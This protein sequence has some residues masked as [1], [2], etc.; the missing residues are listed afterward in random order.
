MCFCQVVE[1]ESKLLANFG[2]GTS[3]AKEGMAGNMANEGK[4]MEKDGGDCSN[5]KKRGYFSFSI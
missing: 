5:S 4:E 3:N 1:E 2:L